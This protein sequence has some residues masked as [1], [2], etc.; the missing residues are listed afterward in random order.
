MGEFLVVGEVGSS[1]GE[2]WKELGN[3]LWCGGR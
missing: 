1:M 2:I 3:V